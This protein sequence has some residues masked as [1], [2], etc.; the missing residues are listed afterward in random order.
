[1]VFL[2]LALACG[3][4]PAAVSAAPGPAPLADGTLAR[5]FT[6]RELHD[7]LPSGARMVLSITEPGK[8]AVERRFTFLDPTDATTTLVTE[9][10]SEGAQLGAP[11]RETVAWADLVEH[12]AFPA[13]W[14]TRKEAAVDTPLGHFDAWEYTVL[15]VGDDGVGVRSHYWFARTLP[16]PPVLLVVEREGVEMMRMT[17]VERSTGG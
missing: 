17:M 4:K 3:P 2:L 9:V 15:K 6:A 5:P 7:A 16:G 13:A 12:A 1:M 10:W 14:T 11:E 8:P